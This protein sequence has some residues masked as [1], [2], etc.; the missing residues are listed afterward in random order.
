MYAAIPEPLIGFE[1]HSST[2]LLADFKYTFEWAGNWGTVKI[3]SAVSW[4]G[5]TVYI[6]I[7]VG[8]VFGAIQH[9]LNVRENTVL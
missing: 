4:L 6:S 5:K 7:L 2:V 8:A 3:K 9:T 1:C